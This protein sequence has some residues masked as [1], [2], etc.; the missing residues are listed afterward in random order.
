MEGKMRR[1]LQEVKECGLKKDRKNEWWDE[2]CKERKREVRSELREWR[3]KGR[4]E[5][6]IEKKEEIYCVMWKKEE[7]G[8]RE[9]GERNEG[10]KKGERDMG[11]NK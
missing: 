1:A 7:G 3:R 4:K 2:E 10:G 5:G 9:M 11:N 6:N 8:E